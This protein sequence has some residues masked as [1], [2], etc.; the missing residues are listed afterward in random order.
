MDNF[1]AEPTLKKEL[2]CV[3]KI[4]QL[5]LLDSIVNYDAAFYQYYQI[6][7]HKQKQTLIC[8]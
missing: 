6:Y 4:V 2:F 8:W 1:F 3:L 7:N 5:M